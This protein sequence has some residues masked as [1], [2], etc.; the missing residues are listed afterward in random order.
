MARWRPPL[1]RTDGSGCSW[2]T[3]TLGLELQAEREMI[4]YAS[5]VET[6]SHPVSYWGSTS[7]VPS[8]ATTPKWRR[9]SESTLPPF[10]SAHAMTAESTRPSWR[11]A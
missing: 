5:G 10:C 8:F 6:A 9:S 11:S 4:P 1:T 2:L 3:E 7:I